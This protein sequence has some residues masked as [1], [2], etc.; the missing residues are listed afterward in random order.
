MGWL[1][2]K[3][4]ISL[5]LSR[6]VVQP[7]IIVKSTTWVLSMR[8]TIDCPGGLDRCRYFPINLMVFTLR[9][10]ASIGSCGT[11]LRGIFGLLGLLV[12]N[13]FLFCGGAGAADFSA[14]LGAVAENLLDFFIKRLSFSR[15]QMQRGLLCVM[16]FWTILSS[17]LRDVKVIL[18]LNRLRFIYHGVASF[19]VLKL[20]ANGP[21]QAFLFLSVCRPSIESFCL[22][23]ELLDKFL[24]VLVHLFMH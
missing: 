11:C 13:R 5:L 3:R 1:H 9:L 6:L 20:S 10:L 4:P 14:I 2:P 15:L 22:L 21:R 17:L 12:C 16:L 8:W 19:R 18:R 24:L 7:T 23:C